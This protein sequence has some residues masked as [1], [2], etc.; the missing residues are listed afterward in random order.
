MKQLKNR[1]PQYLAHDGKEGGEELPAAADIY[2][3][4]SDF[5]RRVKVLDKVAPNLIEDFAFMRRSYLECEYMNR[6]YGRI[7]HGQRSFSVP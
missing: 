3:V 7:T 4:L 5:L 2:A 1:A 6:T